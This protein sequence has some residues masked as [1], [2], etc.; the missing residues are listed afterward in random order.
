MIAMESMHTSGAAGKTGAQE[1]CH[2]YVAVASG[3]GILACPT[4][5]DWEVG[6]SAHCPDALLLIELQPA[7]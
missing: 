7:V 3:P 1:S 4:P 2:G 5:Q 6:S